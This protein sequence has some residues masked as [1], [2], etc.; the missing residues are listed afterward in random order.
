M[1]WNKKNDPWAELRGSKRWKVI[2]DSVLREQRGLCRL[3]GGF[4]EDVHHIEMANSRN[5]FERGNLVALC[6]N[7][8]KKVH[9]SYRRGVSWNL[10][11]SGKER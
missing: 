7:C 5:F 3:C 8:H 2:R 6:N 9:T 11:V 10:I 4:A 1:K